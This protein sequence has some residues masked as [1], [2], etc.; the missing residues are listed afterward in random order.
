MSK[1]E[2]EAH[3]SWKLSEEQKDQL[4]E[5]IAIF[6]TNREI[7]SLMRRYEFPE[8]TTGSITHYRNKYGE[9]VEELKERFRVRALERGWALKEARVALLSDM[10]RD[11]AE[12]KE[13]R[14]TLA[15]E[16]QLSERV[17]DPRLQ[18]VE[19]EYIS[20][21]SMEELMKEMEEEG[22]EEEDVQL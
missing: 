9:Q 1:E 15:I 14:A 10:L 21:K 3:T 16:R 8:I 7:L 6:P 2:Q 4:M 13:V 17:D 11:S 19:L 18:R 12:G 20:P 22:E 5:W